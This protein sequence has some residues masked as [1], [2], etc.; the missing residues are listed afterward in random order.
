MFTI[1]TVIFALCCVLA[2]YHFCLLPVLQRSIRYDVFAIR[3][4]LRELRYLKETSDTEF[5]YDYL[6]ALLNTMVH[7]ARQINMDMFMIMA[8][9]VGANP[10]PHMRKFDKE[11]SDDLKRMLHSS[12]HAMIKVMVLNSP[13]FGIIGTIVSTLW[14]A[15]VLMKTQVVWEK[16]TVQETGHAL[17]FAHA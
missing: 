14:H 15:T 12:L 8:F 9:R 1:V 3:D 6:E 2:Y 13:L 16:I 17:N 7:A 5:C 4:R 10:T 11:A